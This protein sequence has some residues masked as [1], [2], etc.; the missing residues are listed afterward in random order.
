MMIRIWYENYEEKDDGGGCNED[1]REL[2]QF[3]S[4]LH[5]Y[6]LCYFFPILVFR[7]MYF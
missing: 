3:P 1:E 4:C 7:F 6:M 2:S 5:H